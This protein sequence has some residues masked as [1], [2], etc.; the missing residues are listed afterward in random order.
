MAVIRGKL[1]E[2][3]ATTEI[4]CLFKNMDELTFQ[5]VA[6]KAKQAGYLFFPY[7][8]FVNYL[9]EIHEGREEK[10]VANA[11]IDDTEEAYTILV[12]A[13]SAKKVTPEQ[14]KAVL[15]LCSKYPQAVYKEFEGSIKDELI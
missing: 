11:E 9:G 13:P 10:A 5:E 14:R 8:A 4:I 3:Q 1:R 6:M 2:R 12:G 15:E 7:H